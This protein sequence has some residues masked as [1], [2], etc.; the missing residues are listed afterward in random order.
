MPSQASSYAAQ[1]ADTPLA[2]FSFE[3]RDPGPAD[4][5]IDIL[6]CGVCHSDLHTARSEWGG[7][8]Y[9]C[10]PGHEIVGRVTAVGDQVTKFKAGDMAGVGCMVGSCGHCPS[11]AEG[12]E[13]YCETTGMVGTY[14][15]ADAVLGGHTFGGYS[16][17]IVVDEKFV[18]RI[19]H[20]EADLAAA[21]PLLCA[22][23]TTYSPLRHWKVGPGQKVGIVGLGGLGHMGVK[24]AA[25]MGAHV[26][27]FTTSPGKREDAQRL[28]AHDVVVSK[29]VEEMGAHRGSFD[30][31]LNTVAAPHDLDAFL[32]LLKRDGTMVLVGVP[33][34]PH[35]S[36]SVGN[37]IMRR[38]ALAGSLIGGIAETQEMLDFCAEHGLTSDIEM[39]PIQEI[40]TAYDR[41]VRSD[42]KYRFVIDMQSLKNG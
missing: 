34:S 19:S 6:F 25:A 22:G 33:A 26:V 13:Q 18:L 28:G 1:S 14:N 36:P 32:T 38:R 27:V 10:V 30:F 9:P 20:G 41:M 15:G 11:C 37:L 21:A 2:P 31:I 35:P 4:V 40:D 8:L 5:A 39:I 23:I 7:T 24:I 16:D 3:R 29:D 12:E 17:H 42:V